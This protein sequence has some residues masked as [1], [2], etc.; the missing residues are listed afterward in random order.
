[1]AGR[2]SAGTPQYRS[3]AKSA[4]RGSAVMVPASPTAE[5]AATIARV[6]LLRTDPA[7]DW[8]DV[9]LQETQYEALERQ[10]SA[11]AL[12]EVLRRQRP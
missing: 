1:M 6:D 7:A 9:E 12:A 8:R 3:M 4:T 2:P 11:A 10:Q 5:D